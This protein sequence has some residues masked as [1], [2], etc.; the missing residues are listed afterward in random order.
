MKRIY[1]CMG[2]IVL[3][4]AAAFYSSW[5]VQGF[6]CELETALETAATAARTERTG[7]ARGALAQGVQLCQEMRR[8]MRAFLRTEDFTELEG[9]LRAADGYLELGASEEA[10]GEMN[11]AQVSVEN[12]RH[13]ARRWV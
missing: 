12:L 4:L 10:L 2:I 11:R 6:A 3:L 13:L 5:R 9:A 8:E 1:A 7:D